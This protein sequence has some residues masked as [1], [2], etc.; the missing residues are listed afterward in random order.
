MPSDDEAIIAAPERPLG[1]ANQT[2]NDQGGHTAT[3]L[4]NEADRACLEGGGKAM[5]APKGRPSYVAVHEEG[6]LV[7]FVPT[8]KPA[9]SDAS[10][11]QVK[12]ASLLLQRPVPHVDAALNTWHLRWREVH[13]EL[14]ETTTKAT[15]AARQLMRASDPPVFAEFFWNLINIMQD[16]QVKGPRRRDGDEEGRR[17][18]RPSSMVHDVRRIS[19]KRRHRMQGWQGHPILHS[20]DRSQQR[21]DYHQLDGTRQ[22]VLLQ[23]VRRGATVWP[24]LEDLF[25]FGKLLRIEMTP[26]GSQ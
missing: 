24:L 11:L 16:H 20:K 4:F 22:S 3:R 23:V 9:G 7:A 25:S 19:N 15:E 2:Y 18:R 14:L 10:R 6:A 26:A 1:T 13:P 8:T 17:Q 12:G 21:R 5:C